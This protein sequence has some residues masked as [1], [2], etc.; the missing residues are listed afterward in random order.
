MTAEPACN[1]GGMIQR[2]SSLVLLGANLVP[3][4]GVLLFGWDLMGILLL[5]WTETVLI[6]LINVLRM[7]RCKSP[8]Y[9]G[10]VLP[11][12]ALHRTANLR[13]QH[14]PGMP[15]TAVELF[16]V[17]FFLVHYGLFGVAH[18]SAIVGIFSPQGLGANLAATVASLWQPAYWLPVAAIAASHLYSYV[19]NFV[20]RGE[21]RRTNV[22]QLMLR[23]Y[24]RIVA[25]HVSIIAGAA[26]V[27]LFDDPLPMLLVLVLAKILL[28][29]RL[30]DA[31]RRRF[32]SSA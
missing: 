7:I 3:L 31:E 4:G 18:L 27:T 20:G 17:P 25:M 22:M 13:Y 6:G 23:P 10:D 28:D 32:A 24:G 21:Y 11:V 30:H 5:Y 16:L 15:S 19:V 26:C 1:H 14:L 2:T 29:L 9:P 12:P 8:S